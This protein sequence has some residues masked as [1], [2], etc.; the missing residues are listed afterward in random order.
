MKIELNSGEFET[1]NDLGLLARYCAG[2]ELGAFRN[3]IE[4][5]RISLSRVREAPDGKD[6]SCLVEVDL[7]AGDDVTAEANDSNPYVAIHWALEQAGWAVSS[8][9]PRGPNTP[10]TTGQRALGNGEPGLAA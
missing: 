5:V 1:S 2:F 9:Q 10:Q 4:A 8:R 6:C 7:I 3:Q